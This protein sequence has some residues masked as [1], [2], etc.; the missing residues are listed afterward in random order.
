MNLPFDKIH[1]TRW[2]YGLLLIPWFG[3]PIYSGKR[4]WIA[5]FK[6]YGIKRT[7]Y[8]GFHNCRLYGN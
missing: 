6:D 4:H 5:W 7:D 2:S 8:L 3:K 1:D